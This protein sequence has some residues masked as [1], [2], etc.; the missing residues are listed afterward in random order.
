LQSFIQIIHQYNPDNIELQN[1]IDPIPLSIPQ[2]YNNPI[3]PP[4]CPAKQTNQNPKMLN[5]KKTPKIKTEKKKNYLEK[6]IRNIIT[7]YSRITTCGTCPHVPMILFPLLTFPSMQHS[8]AFSPSST[9][10][11]PLSF[12][13]IKPKIQT[14]VFA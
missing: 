3:N 8:L 10:N 12:Q 5:K 6:R 1:K 4:S 9:I 13:E 2:M 7:S 14:S 11:P